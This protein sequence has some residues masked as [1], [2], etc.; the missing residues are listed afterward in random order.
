[1]SV[2]ALA[3]PT[4]FPNAALGMDTIQ[5]AYHY[6]DTSVQNAA[7]VKVLCDGGYAVAGT[8]ATT[9]AQIYFFK[10]DKTGQLLV[11]KHYS[12]SVSMSIFNMLYI[13][14]QG[15]IIAGK[16][17]SYPFVMYVNLEGVVQWSKIYNNIPDAGVQKILAVSNGYLVV[18]SLQNQNVIFKIN[19]NG[20]F[21]GVAKLFY[22]AANPGYL[23]YFTD[24][25]ST[26]DGGF[27]VV[28]FNYQANIGLVKL[29]SNLT[30]LWSKSFGGSGNSCED[31]PG[32]IQETP[33]GG[34]LI[35]GYTKGEGNSICNDWGVNYAGVS[36][37]FLLKTNNT[38]T[39]QWARVV[40]VSGSESVS[41]FYKGTGN[42]YLVNINTNGLGQNSGTALA[43]VDHTNGILSNFKL[44]D[45]SGEESGSIMP[46]GNGGYLFSGNTNSI[47]SNYQ[48]LLVK[49]NDA[50]A[51]KGCFG[52]QTTTLANAAVTLTTDLN[53]STM[54]QAVS[55]IAV[56][57]QPITESSN[58]F[59]KNTS[60]VRACQ[61]QSLDLTANSGTN[62][63]W[64]GPNGFVSSVQSPVILS[65][66][67]GTYYTTI[68]DV[69][70]C[71]QTQLLTVQTL[72]VPPSVSLPDT[73]VQLGATVNLQVAAG[74]AQYKWS[75]GT[76][77]TATNSVKPSVTT[78]YKV[79][80]TDA[81]LCTATDS[82]TVTVQANR[83]TDSLALV[84]LYNATNGANWTNKWNLSQPMT[85]WYGILLNA[86]GCVTYIDLDGLPN[87]GLSVSTGNNLTGTLPNSLGNL[88]SLQALFLNRNNLSGTIPATLGNLTNLA[89]LNL[90]KNKFT[91]SIPDS[92]T[93]LTNLIWFSAAANQLTSNVPS[94]LANLPNMN[95]ANV[96]N[97][98]FTF[99]NVLSFV[100]NAR[101]MPLYYPQDSIYTDTT[102]LKYV[103]N[104]LSV[105]LGIDGALTSNKYYWYKNGTF[106]D[107]TTVNQLIF[108]S[109]QL[110]NA[111]VYTCQVKNPNAPLLTLYSR[112][113]NIIV[114]G[115][116]ATS[117]I[118]KKICE[119]TPYTLPKG[120]I[121]SLAGTYY[122]T[123]RIPNRVDSIVTIHL[124]V[125][126]PQT[127]HLRDSVVCFV[128][129]THTVIHTIRN[130][131]GCD[132]FEIQRFR[133]EQRDTTFSIETVCDTLDEGADT[134][135]IAT[136][137]RCQALL[138]THYIF[139]QCECLGQTKIYNA[140]IPNDGDD[141]NDVFFIDYLERYTPN[142]L[143]ITDKRNQVVYRTVNYKNDWTGTNSNGDRLP[144]GTYNYV[145][146]TT[147]PVTQAVCMRVGVLDIK[148]IP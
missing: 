54:A 29:N 131:Q 24:A 102:F 108:N 109:L 6:G 43:H 21:A 4:C 140:L 121:V 111:G 146:R 9:L 97:N 31:Y 60:I 128:R 127:T 57:N 81:N 33:D 133:L 69:N 68:T 59:N 115:S 132:D 147:H 117:E 72:N 144:A 25:I 48:H 56:Q 14:N 52:L 136:R 11:S 44:L 112:K 15:F 135:V 85:N 98:K 119:G 118:N 78:V 61:G 40:G 26:S 27:A 39:V 116:N 93:K 7:T 99:S 76:S 120:R 89:W 28:G 124:S 62:F 148:Y 122:D 3:Q 125:I 65:P 35:G 46:T 88:Q 134:T 138:I 77:T 123:I 66:T 129:D 67:T 64:T 19:T 100:G 34:L 16:H 126:K 82:G 105:N 113:I 12:S 63:S 50:L 30:P 101:F 74:F 73:T 36:D 86:Q 83:C 137:N 145:F 142:E 42:D 107:S 20:T 22:S 5:F 87:F 106:Y 71:S 32:C 96:D 92:L 139:E 13:E 1:M 45:R 91:G 80:V 18:V 37:G 94:N 10:T 49:F 110:T 41:S 47:G 51:T 95:T 103:G 90:G 84:D 23:D 38:G 70:G 2:I 79:T 75:S 130:A 104:S 55:S 143:I 17:G 8:T 141:K 53:Y 114:S 58:V